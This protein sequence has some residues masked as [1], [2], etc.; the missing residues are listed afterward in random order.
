MTTLGFI[1][2]GV[3]GEP[4]CRN[5]ATRTGNRMLAFDLRPEPGERLAR[6]GIEVAPSAAAVVR[7]AEIVFLS[8]PGGEQVRALSDTVLLPGARAGQTIVDMSTAPVALA[9]ELAEAFAEKGAD[10]ADAP[11][12]RTR[13]AAIDGTLS[14][15]V[16]ASEEVFQRIEPFLACAGSDITHCGEVGAGQ[17]VKIMNNKILIDTVNAIAEAM[18]IGKRAGIDL[19]MLLNTLSKGSGDSFALRN[20][21]R[22]AMLSRD[23]PEPAFGADYAL[24]DLE[25][26]F[27]LARETGVAV[28]TSEVSAERLKAASSAGLGAKYWPAIYEVVDGE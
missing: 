10:F 14:I 6:A 7:E 9:R 27:D 12:A 25:Y 15:T 13:Q 2:L 26:A 3:M 16:G 1:G 19:E 18:A 28:P 21:A 23:Y 4:M 11:V 24:K 22:K 20:H 5:M 17:F 8:L